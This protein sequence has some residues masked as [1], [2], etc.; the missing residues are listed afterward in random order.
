MRWLQVIQPT[1]CRSPHRARP[2]VMNQE[3]WWRL[4]Q[5]ARLFPKEVV[6]REPE[7]L[8]ALAW[9]ARS[10]YQLPRMQSLVMQA[11]AA[12]A[13]QQ[14]DPA[15]T[16]RARDAEQQLEGEIDL[17]RT[18]L[19]YWQGDMAGV[20][21]HGTRGLALT[22]VELCAVRNVALMLLCGAYQANGDLP[23]AYALHAEQLA[24]ASTHGPICLRS[25]WLARAPVQAIAGDLPALAENINRMLALVQNLPWD[26][27]TAVIYYHLA[28]IHYY[29]NN[30]AGVEQALAELLPRRYH[31]VPTI[32][33]HSAFLLA[34]TYQAQQR[35]AEANTLTTFALDF[36]NETG[37]VQLAEIVRAFAGRTCPAPGPPVMTPAFW[38]WRWR[39]RPCSQR[40][41]SI[42]RT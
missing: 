13:A 15:S 21:R 6:A 1:R 36:C 38:P 42:R 41:S 30:L 29:Q 27:H 3:E 4:E 2:A 34:A 16:G 23:G 5:W 8:V 40:L 7:L 14:N 32:F 28:A 9:V 37:Q 26:A 17:L 12:F 10:Q 11:A 20:M 31:A 35:A 25:Y 22:P 33:I 24:A 39:T 18:F 19:C